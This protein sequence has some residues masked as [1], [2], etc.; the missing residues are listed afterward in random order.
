MD[1]ARIHRLLASSK[2]SYGKLEDPK[3]FG[4]TIRSSRGWDGVE[5]VFGGDDPKAKSRVSRLTRHLKRYS[6]GEI[7][8]AKATELIESLLD[9]AKQEKKLYAAQAPIRNEIPERLREFLPRNIV[10]KIDD[11]GKI[12]NIIDLYGN[13]REDLQEKVRTMKKLVRRYN[14]IAKQVKKDMRSDDEK[15][16]LAALITAIIME[17]GIRP[18]AEGNMVIL[19]SDEGPIEVETFGATTLRPEHV[20]FVRNNFAELRFLG[21]KGT[22]NVASLTDEDIIAELQALAESTSSDRLFVTRDGEEVSYS[23]LMNYFRRNFKG[24]SPTD[25]RKLRATE[26]VQEALLEERDDLMAAIREIVEEEREDA[27]EAI[28]EAIYE[29]LERA[30]IKSQERL[31][32]LSPSTTRESYINPQVLLDMLARGDVAKSIDEALLTGDKYL[33]FNIDEFKA[34]ALTGN[35][36]WWV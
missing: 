11:S 34:Q 1:R 8:K 25:F 36:A 29:A 33:V 16:R 31:S 30:E 9:T 20:K 19:Q 15:T 32:H 10:V 4:R 22:E 28:V 23:D 26:Q 21:K 13:Q 24:F 7:S 3:K 18:G 27:N 5:K 6:S 17:T 35:P 12:R 2:K 14:S